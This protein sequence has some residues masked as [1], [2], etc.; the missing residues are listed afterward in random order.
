MHLHVGPTCKSK[1][2]FKNENRVSIQILQILLITIVKYEAFFEKKMLLQ[3]L[4][5]MHGH[6]KV[7]SLVDAHGHIF[8]INL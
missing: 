4:H 7:V 8:C 1:R 3:K 6:V 5:C 2:A